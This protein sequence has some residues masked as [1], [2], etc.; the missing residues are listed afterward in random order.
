[1]FDAT[2]AYL[3]IVDG[4]LVSDPGE[5][6]EMS[7]ESL[8]EHVEALDEHPPLSGDG[9]EISGSRGFIAVLIDE[10]VFHAYFL[11]YDEGYETACIGFELFA[12]PELGGDTRTTVGRLS[13]DGHISSDALKEVLRLL[14][15]HMSPV[16]YIKAAAEQ[17]RR[18][19]GD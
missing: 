3:S 2:V 10:Y 9:P 19:S 7:L 13:L 15:S 16:S 14:D 12:H 6:E 11:D 5:R 8:L 1:M 18:D 4:N 17:F